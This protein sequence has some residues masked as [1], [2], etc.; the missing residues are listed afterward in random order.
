MLR[1][2]SS[3]D[4]GVINS[5]RNASC[6]NCQEYKMAATVDSRDSIASTRASK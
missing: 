6:H 4:I 1:Q 2:L 3:G 5:E